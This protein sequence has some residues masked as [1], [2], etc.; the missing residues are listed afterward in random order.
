MS[1]SDIPEL[2]TSG[3]RQF[4]LTTGAIVAVLFGIVFPYVFDRPWP[5]WPWV[6]FSVLAVWAIVAPNTLKPIYHG[7][8]RVGMA[9]GRI[10]TQ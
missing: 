7:W 5:A 4:G 3:L 8:M 1:A 2:D 6:V 10:T 9:L